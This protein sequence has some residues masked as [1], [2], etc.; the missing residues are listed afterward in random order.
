MILIPLGGTGQRFKQ[1][2]YV[3]PKAFIKVSG[4]PI[5]SHLLDNLKIDN[6][7][8]YI[9][10][11]KEYKTFDIENK[12]TQLYPKIKFKFLCLANNTRGAAET[13]NI[14]LKQLISSQIK[15][16]I[17]T[18]QQKSMFDK[19]VLCL[20]CD[21][22]YLCDII[23]LWNGKNCV[24]TFK[25][26]KQ[27]PIFSYIKEK[28][29]ESIFDIKEKE[30]ISDDACTGA[31]GFNSYYELY[32]YTSKIINK[33]IRQKNEFYISGVINSM[34]NDGIHFKNI[35]LLNKHYFSLG[36]P[37]NVMEYE[38]PFI[39]DL[40]G[41]LVNTDNIYIDV[42]K[43][44]MKEYKLSIDENFF[45]FF[46]Q[47][48]NDILFLKSIFPYINTNEIKK[49]SA[50]KDNLFIKYLEK[51][52]KNIFINGADKFIKENNNRRMC[53]VTSCNKKAAIYILKKTKIDQ[54]IQFIIASEDCEK[55]KP[56]KLPYQMAV[57]FLKCD[58]NKC[59]IFEDSNSG[60]KSA[61]SLGGAKICL[62]LNDKSNNFILNSNVYRISNYNDFD[63]SKLLTNKKVDIK[64]ILIEKLNNLPINDIII[65]NDNLKTGYICDI[66]SLTLKFNNSYDNVILKLENE[67]NEL[68]T[69]ARKINLY[70]N[71]LYFY[72]NISSIINLNIPKFFSSVKI[73]QKKGIILEDLNNYNGVF[74]INLNKDIDS[75]ICV[76]RKISEMHNRFYYINKNDL[77]PSMKNLKT[78]NEITYYKELINIRYNKFLDINNI[79]LSENETKIFNNIYANYEKI[80]NILSS[81][82]LNFC[83][84]DCK[85]PNI[86]YKKNGKNYNPIFLDWQYIHLNKGMSDIVFLLVES[87]EY[88]KNIIDLVL[89][90][91]YNKT[92]MYK[93]FQDFM[94]DF[95]LCLCTFPFFV[96]IWFNS[97]NRDNLLDK[98][99]PINFMRNTLK[100][101]NYFLDN[102]FFI[103]LDKSEI[104]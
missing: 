93:N 12:L 4:K 95:K 64:N 18:V 35:S 51:Y 42:W 103:S 60:Y 14:A 48:K 90:Y 83:H 8:V 44:I 61:K 80:T 73:N 89:N 15:Y 13:I 11:N 97:E 69:V 71:E 27:C 40:D 20:D 5:I 47:G 65:N 37:K 101:Y 25:D 33:N 58:K 16:P 30:K 98:V 1:N 94:F 32:Q 34:L 3:E 10:Y 2:G 56:D 74:N 76:V 21:N 102:D 96:M 24:F 82:P 6:R 46:I 70:S 84:G 78:L 19:P 53:I 49:I 26:Y 59:T 87:I 55:H 63:Y 29:D 66:K 99:F 100:Y 54:Y 39:F 91:Y 88:D 85:S 38:H 72:E 75:L 9:P 31:Y 50:L 79:M 43:D 81:Y 77:I 36:T 86:F 7:L 104:L 57:N 28:D 92:I 52:N 45:K 67:D 23:N 62:L 41:T 22:F 68:S 17:D